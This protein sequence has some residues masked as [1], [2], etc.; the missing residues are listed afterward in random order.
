MKITKTFLIGFGKM[1]KGLGS[2]DKES[3]YGALL[4]QKRKFNLLTVIDKKMK[5][6]C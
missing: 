5:G 1:G 4:S 6:Y 3:H 2:K